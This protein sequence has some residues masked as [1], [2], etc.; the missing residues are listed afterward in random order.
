M[1]VCWN[2]HFFYRKDTFWPI[3]ISLR[4][5]L[6]SSFS[7]VLTLYWQEVWVVGNARERGLNIYKKDPLPCHS[8]HGKDVD[9]GCRGDRVVDGP[10]PFEYRFRRF[11]WRTG[12]KE[13]FLLVSRL[14]MRKWRERSFEPS[15]RRRSEESTRPSNPPHVRYSKT[16]IFNMTGWLAKGLS[17]LFGW[18]KI[19]KK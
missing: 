12:I 16:F 18:G 13:T 11:R 17:G 8:H 9:G 4:N 3:Q 5:R 15:R 1:C 19:L 6:V 2:L 10:S 7:V 14:L